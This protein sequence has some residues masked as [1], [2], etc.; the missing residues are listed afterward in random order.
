MTVGN[1]SA[2]QTQIIER[3]AVI[4]NFPIIASTVLMTDRSGGEVKKELREKLLADWKHWKKV[5]MEGVRT[6]GD[7]DGKKA[8][9]ATH[10][11]ESQLGDLAGAVECEQGDGACRHLHQAKDHLG[12]VDVHSKVRNVERKPVVHQHIGKPETDG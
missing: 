1:T 3:E 11:Q 7:K 9:R 2:E 8:C 12:Q 4:P 5:N 10:S 6:T